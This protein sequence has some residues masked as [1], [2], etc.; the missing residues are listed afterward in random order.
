MNKKKLGMTI[1]SLALVGAIAVGGTLAYLTDTSSQVKN[2]F[3]LTNDL[4]IILDE[5]PVDENGQE[6]TETRV[7]ENIYDDLYANQLLDKD[8]TVTLTNRSIDQ[9]VFVAVKENSNVNVVKYNTVANE[10]TWNVYTDPDHSDVKIFYQY[11]DVDTQNVDK[12]SNDTTLGYKEG[13]QLQPIFENVKVG[14]VTT[15]TNN[16]LGNIL[17]GAATIQANGIE[18]DAGE[19]V[20][21]AYNQI[22]TELLKLVGI[23]E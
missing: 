5:A 14:N 16:D 9:Y 22:S 23:T 10:G 18:A 3:T 12:V 2:T 4:D 1:G 19:E 6:T 13:I 15:A 20:N 21:V 17:V 11:V 8:P 7:Q